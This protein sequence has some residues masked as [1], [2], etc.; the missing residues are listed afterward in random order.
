MIIAACPFDKQAKRRFTSR[1]KP[2][3]GICATRLYAVVA[4][5]VTSNTTIDVVLLLSRSIK[6]SKR[7]YTELTSSV[8][9][10][11]LTMLRA[12]L[13]NTSCSYTKKR[14]CRYPCCDQCSW[15]SLRSTFTQAWISALPKNW[16]LRTWDCT[17]AFSHLQIGV[18]HTSTW[19]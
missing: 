18:E 7:L 13:A 5:S 3:R 4:F 11:A 9:T 10:Y 8:E 17:R 16:C 14:T 15:S 6:H 12:R 1:V 19:P 2:A